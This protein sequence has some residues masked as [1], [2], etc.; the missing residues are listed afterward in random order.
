MVYSCGMRNGSASLDEQ[1]TLGYSFL[2]DLA[3]KALCSCWRVLCR[4]RIPR[5]SRPHNASQE[6]T[7]ISTFA[8]VSESR[9]PNRRSNFTSGTE[10]RNRK[11]RGC[12]RN[13]R[14]NS[15]GRKGPRITRISRIAPIAPWASRKASAKAS[16]AKSIHVIHGL[17]SSP[18]NLRSLRTLFRLA[19]QSQCPVR[20]LH[21]AAFLA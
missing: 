5:N 17:F 7:A 11:Q 12:P 4:D 16:A 8:S 20:R 2:I 9:T 18:Q 15:I 1:G 6:R 19:L 14:K 21:L 10:R 3:R 13:T